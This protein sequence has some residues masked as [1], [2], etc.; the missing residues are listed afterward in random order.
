MS[1]EHYKVREKLEDMKGI[2]GNNISTSILY[3]NVLNRYD[4]SFG[5][6]Q[7]DENRTGGKN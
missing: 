3:S 2:F 7:R 6:K 4:T 1:D 5:K